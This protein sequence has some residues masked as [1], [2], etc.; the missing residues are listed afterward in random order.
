MPRI[1]EVL[2]FIDESEPGNP[3][4]VTTEQLICFIIVKWNP[5]QVPRMILSFSLIFSPWNWETILRDF[6]SIL[7]GQRIPKE[8]SNVL[9]KQALHRTL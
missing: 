4:E 9:T 5:F 6:P 3:L 1:E 7:T 8:R 2:L